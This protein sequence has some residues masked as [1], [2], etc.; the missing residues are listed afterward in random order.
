MTF[1]VHSRGNF[2]EIGWLRAYLAYFSWNFRK[3]YDSQK[4]QD[5]PTGFWGCSIP[6]ISRDI[7]N[8]IFKS[9]W[10]NSPLASVYSSCNI[11]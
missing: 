5:I 3:N 9:S 8:G 6:G 4:P 2:G 1:F 10:T 11:A 7:P